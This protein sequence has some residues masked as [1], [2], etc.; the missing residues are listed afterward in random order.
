M[1]L[2]AGEERLCAGDAEEGK[3]GTDVGICYQA[4][5]KTEEVS[6]RL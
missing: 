2:C 5:N 4:R 6:D 3:R 1:L